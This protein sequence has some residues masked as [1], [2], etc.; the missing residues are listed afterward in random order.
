MS[1]SSQLASPLGLLAKSHQ[2]L[3][4]R[5]AL[6][7]FINTKC[8]WAPELEPILTVITVTT[9][10]VIVFA[11]VSAATFLAIFGHRLGWQ[12]LKGLTSH[13]RLEYLET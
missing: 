12:R 2:D 10:M 11:V 4:G 3:A 7:R 13:S 5:L 9:V 6:D 8:P 1:Q